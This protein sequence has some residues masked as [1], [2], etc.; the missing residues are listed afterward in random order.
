MTLFLGQCL[1]EV[2]RSPGDCILMRAD[3]ANSAN[4]FVISLGGSKSGNPCERLMAP[5]LLDIRVIR[6][7]TESVKPAVLVDSGF[8]TIL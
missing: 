2:L 8:I 7:M 4:R 3:M 5:Y 1:T 6:R